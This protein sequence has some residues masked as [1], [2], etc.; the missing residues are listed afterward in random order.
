M[1]R[2]ATLHGWLLSLLLLSACAGGAGDPA[3]RAA[4]NAEVARRPDAYANGEARAWQVRRDG[5]VRGLVWGTLHI[6]YGGDTVLPAPIRARFYAAADLTVEVALDR[7]PNA[8]RTMRAAF[9]R[10]ARRHHR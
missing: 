8:M 5:A 1:L 4:A 7:V 9:Q 3:F 2:R 6:G 10:A